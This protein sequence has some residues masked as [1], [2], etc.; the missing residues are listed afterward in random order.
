[1]T[2]KRLIDDMDPNL[3]VVLLLNPY[4]GHYD[5][6]RWLDNET[7]YISKETINIRSILLNV[8]LTTLTDHEVYTVALNEQNN[9]PLFI[10][11]TGN[12][13]E[14]VTFKANNLERFKILKHLDVIT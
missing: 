9:K 11:P 2:T 13:M 3:D 6:C 8:D 4:T 1:M 14:L 7:L 10:D 5:P 12:V